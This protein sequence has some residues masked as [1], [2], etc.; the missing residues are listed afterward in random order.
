MRLI[1][2]ENRVFRVY[3]KPVE[4]SIP[5]R[6]VEYVVVIQNDDIGILS[7]YRHHL[8]RACVRAPL[9]Q[10]FRIQ[11]LPQDRLA[12]LFRLFRWSEIL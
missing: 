11:D 8:V 7:T 10:F 6:I 2:E 1:H 12:V 3:L 4:E 5:H 9:L